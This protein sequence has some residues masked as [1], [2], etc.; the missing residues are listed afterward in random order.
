MMNEL[1]EH[2]E[3][4]RNI[5]KNSIKLQLPI[6]I[7][8]YTLPRNMEAY[9]QRVLEIFLEECYQDHLKEYL[10]FCLGEL[11][12]NSKKANTKRVYFQEKGLDIN[13]PEDYELGMKTFKDEAFD[14]M[15]YYLDLQRKAGLYVKLVLQL[16]ADKVIIEIRNNSII[17]PAERARI[18]QKLDNVQQYKTMDE[19][20]NKVLDTTEGAGLGII[21]IILMLQRVG[22][23]KENYQVFTTD[24]ETVTRIILPGNE[25]IFAAIDIMSYELI[26][27]RDH[28][29]VL[30]YRYKEVNDLAAVEKLDRNA[31]LNCVRKD[32][33]LALLLLK[34]AQEK[35]KN[36]IS[37][38]KA[39][40]LLSDDELKFIFSESNP[41]SYMIEN[42]Q[43]LEDLFFHAERVAYFAFS[44]YK[45]I[46]GF[47]SKYDAEDIYTLGLLNSLGYMFLQTETKEQSDYMQELAEQF[48]EYSDK[49]L[50]VFNFGN[51]NNYLKRAYIKKMNFDEDIS[52]VLSSWNNSSKVRDDLVPV[53]D[54]LYMS[55]MMQYYD[56]KQVEFYQVDKEIL[57]KFKIGD[58][59]QFKTILVQMK[60][61]FINK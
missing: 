30:E 29:P 35:D 33:N 28:I 8:S 42:T 24:E 46:P 38:Y 7:T 55:E 23:S 11:L 43:E 31:L 51:S 52:M 27:M 45:N 39:M 48:E 4:E 61:N 40:E 18:Q 22:L 13:N 5:I 12:T 16:K 3:I 56:E 17:T 59:K 26:Y 44:L 25:K 58:E 60:D 20:V 34:Y 2:L 9:I 10:K 37:L 47:D 6:E 54:L 21:I 14:N 53:T 50:D 49:I 19:V 41:A 32:M 36:C 1:D 57:K 15:N